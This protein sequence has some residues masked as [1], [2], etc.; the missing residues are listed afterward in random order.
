MP[1]QPN[2]QSSVTAGLAVVS[3]CL[4]LFS[5]ALFLGLGATLALDGTG[6]YRLL[7]NLAWGGVALA[8]VSAMVMLWFARQ[9]WRSMAWRVGWRHWLLFLQT[10][11][12][13]GALAAVAYGDLRAVLY[14]PLVVGLL[15]TLALWIALRAEQ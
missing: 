11:L 3:A 6:R 1:S 9:V 2:R 13:L 8:V 4:G 15:A 12:F 14:V 10:V 5:A 7:A